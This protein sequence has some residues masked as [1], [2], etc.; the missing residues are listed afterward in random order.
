MDPDPVADV[1][2]QRIIGCA[3]TVHTALGPGLLESIYRDC[4]LIELTSQHLVA[5]T[6]QRVRVEYRR[7]RVR[8]DLR[9][10]IL[11]EGKV[12]VEVKSVEQLHPVHKAQV[13]TYLKLAAKP[14]G[15]ILNFNVTKMSA[16]IRRLDHP[17][18]YARRRHGLESFRFVRDRDS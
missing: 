14:A 11:V 15:L 6:E 10:D 4:L 5:R 13:L 1:F 16:G 8:D 3:L 2:C 17:A 7:Q 12:I 18:I 9:I